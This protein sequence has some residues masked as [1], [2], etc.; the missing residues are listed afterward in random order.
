MV[1][2]DFYQSDYFLVRG[3]LIKLLK[4]QQK[5]MD[6]INL[7]EVMYNLFKKH[8]QT[9]IKMVSYVKNFPKVNNLEIFPE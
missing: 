8:P 6:D 7:I 5:K 9:K 2:L 4:N 3:D 1:G